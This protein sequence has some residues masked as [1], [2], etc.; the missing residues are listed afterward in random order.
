M[1]KPTR[2]SELAPG[3]TG[4]FFALLA[5]RACAAS[6]E[7]KPYYTCRFRDA[8]RLATFMV[9]QDG[10]W[11]ATCERDWQEGQFFKIRARYDEHR[12]YGPQIEIY[13]LRPATK[14]DRA[15]GFNPLDF[16]DR[17]RFDADALFAELVKLTETAIAD[18]PLRQLVLT[19]LERHAAALKIVP[20]TLR[21]FYPFCGGLLEHTLNVARSCLQLVEKYQAYYPDVKPPL[22][23]DLVLA[24]AVL[25]DIGRV[26]EYTADPLNFQATVPGQLLGHLFLGRDLVRDTARELG[27]VNAELLQ[28]LE[29]ILITH[30][31]LPEW[32]SPRLP[33]IPECLIIHHA[34]DL[35][36]KME[37]YMRCLTR[38]EETGPFT[39]R[40]ASLNRQLLK[41]RSV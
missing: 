38:D 18:A 33:L 22:N 34:D 26:L 9:W 15:D 36:A 11:F 2:L 21:R 16:V 39:A 27:N 4:D 6:R 19:I 40:D 31:N 17:S 37:M 14:E 25:H 32:G 1:Q 41:G 13:G 3:Q 8:R 10:P 29:H 30:L 28:L 35:D 20:A 23:R 24:G 12:T 7:G 5:G